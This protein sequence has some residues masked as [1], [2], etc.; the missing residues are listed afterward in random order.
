VG[1]GVALGKEK[2][3]TSLLNCFFRVYV[4]SNAPVVAA[5]PTIWASLLESNGAADKGA[6]SGSTALV[7]FGDLTGAIEVKIDPSIAQKSH[8]SNHQR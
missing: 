6:R 7:I 2:R 1:S 4:F 3:A 8:Q 5:A